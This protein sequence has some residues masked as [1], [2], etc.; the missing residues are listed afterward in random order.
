MKIAKKIVGRLKRYARKSKILMS[1]IQNIVLQ[2]MSI[3]TQAEKIGEICRIDS[4][5]T[6]INSS[7]SKLNVIIRIF[8]KRKLYIIVIFL[9]RIQSFVNKKR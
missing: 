1:N 7:P 3:K 9:K 2:N 6:L 5:N 4:I 8:L